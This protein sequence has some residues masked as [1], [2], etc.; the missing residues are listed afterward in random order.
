MKLAIMQPYFLPYIGYFQLIQAVDCFVVY[1]NIKYTKK[2]WIN[3]NRLLKNAS[4]A[5]FTVPL[6]SAADTLDVIDRE[7]AEDFNRAKL[8][9]QFRESYRRAPQFAAVW[10]MLERIVMN[11]R[12]S[13]FHYVHDAIG[14]VC[15]YLGITTPI[16]VS[17][18]VDIDHDL[19][20]QD[21]VLALCEKVG[22]RHYVNAIGGQELYAHAAFNAR[23]IE[24]SF[25]QSAPVTYAQFDEPFVPWLSIVDVMMFNTPQQIG[26][27][28][29]QRS[30]V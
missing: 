9:N 21:K 13:L 18:T 19:R 11:P 29:G 8:L 15:R 10:P 24:L 1:D 12:T 14:E 16:V 25:L 28:L 5:T 7:I 4:D 27:L 17:S 23:D 22:A 20:G 30:F 2:G 6:K 26:A 3:R